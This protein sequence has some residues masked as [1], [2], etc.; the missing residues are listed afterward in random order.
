MTAF[1]DA[2]PKRLLAASLQATFLPRP[3][4]I[5]VLLLAFAGALPVRLV[6]A[7]AP[8]GPSAGASDQPKRT[9][10]ATI[11]S[12]LA[13]LP[14][15][16]L[17]VTSVIGG[18]LLFSTVLS[19]PGEHFHGRHRALKALFNTIGVAIKESIGIAG[20]CAVLVAVFLV[21]LTP[22]FYRVA[23]RPESQVVRP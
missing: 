4:S 11:R 12:S 14:F 9:E 8:A 7:T 10:R 15:G 18:L 2:V 5:A 1:I 22:W 21:V 3:K 13:G 16:A 19:S 6:A 17:M 23:R 20:A